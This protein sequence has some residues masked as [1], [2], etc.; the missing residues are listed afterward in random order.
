MSHS[1]RKLI[2]DMIQVEFSVLD[3]QGHYR[4]EHV[5]AD[6]LRKVQE[7]FLLQIKNPFTRSPD[8]MDQ[9][10]SRVAAGLERI[11]SKREW[12]QSRAVL[13]RENLGCVRFFPFKG[14]NAISIEPSHAGVQAVLDCSGKIQFFLSLDINAKT[15]SVKV[16]HH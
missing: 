14:H 11:G 9:K 10:I 15:A 6:I 16:P 2:P 8:V 3:Q 7:A 12:G 4:A 13:Q 5:N 1:I